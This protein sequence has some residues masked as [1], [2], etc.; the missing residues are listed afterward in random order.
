MLNK[1][2]NYISLSKMAGYYTRAFFRL[3]IFKCILDGRAFCV[4]SAE[5]F[6]KESS[7]RE[8][9]IDFALY[10]LQTIFT[11]SSVHK[12]KSVICAFQLD[13]LFTELFE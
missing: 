1:T 5:Y 6:R 7:H 12:E 4:P 11:A 10:F 9:Q 3:P 8:T 13:F 2:W